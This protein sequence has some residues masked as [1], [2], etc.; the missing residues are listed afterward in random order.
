[1]IVRYCKLARGQGTIGAH[2]RGPET[3]CNYCMARLS[4][5]LQSTVRR[6][7]ITP[8]YCA[9]SKYCFLQVATPSS[10][11]NM[12]NM[13]PQRS[14]TT[15]QAPYSPSALRS[16]TNSTSLARSLADISSERFARRFN[17]RADSDHQLHRLL[18]SHF[19]LNKQDRGL[20]YRDGLG[21]IQDAV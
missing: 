15:L 10:S 8:E 14:S 11:S 19:C 2:D 7:S 17:V 12:S 5:K 20:A 4:G 1:M 18:H 16:F 6:S 21:D 13:T 9:V 3:Y